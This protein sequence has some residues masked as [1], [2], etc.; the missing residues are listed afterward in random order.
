MDRDG[1]VFVAGTVGIGGGSGD[2]LT[3]KYSPAGTALWINRY[4]GPANGDDTFSSIAADSN[5]TVLVAGKSWYGTHYDY[6]TVKYA[7]RFLGHS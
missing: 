5:G 1:N 7:A 2:W 6:V 3:L 4:N